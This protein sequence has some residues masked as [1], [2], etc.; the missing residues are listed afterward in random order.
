MLK[1]IMYFII[2]SF[3]I[4][5][6]IDISNP[7]FTN[8]TTIATI[9]LQ[10]NKSVVEKDEEIEI[11]FNIKEQKVAA[12]N[13]NIYFDETKFEFI[14][15][16]EN[17]NVDGNRIIIVWY[18]SQGGN[19]ARHGELGKIKFKAKENG[20]ANFVVNGD[21]YSSKGQLI[22]TNFENIQVQVGKDEIISE[23]EVIKDENTNLETLAIENV[24]LYPPFN[25]DI[26]QYNA[27]V[28]NEVTDLNILA[29]PED[30]RGK[31]EVL[32]GQDIKEGN[33]I[34]NIK[35]TAPNGITTRE[36]Q[37]NVYKRNVEEE[38][39]YKVEQEEQK[40]KLEQAYEIEKTSTTS[41]DNVSKQVEKKS[42]SRY[43][44]IGIIFFIVILSI[45]IGIIYYKKKIM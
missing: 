30:E 33:N 8:A 2:T 45:I 3:I 27:E 1:K 14:S 23:P 34:I 16:P 28:S 21:F 24:L 31:A 41:N 4:F 29:I 35:V 19:G 22:Q 17:I 18:D 32:G 43:W 9:Y 44:I 40:E 38:E 10:A 12:F 37:V 7:I 39:K 20:T 36:Y 6:I 11:T 13:T 5:S 42:T 26:T 15:G 25:N